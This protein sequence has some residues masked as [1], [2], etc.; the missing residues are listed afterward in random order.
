[1]RPGEQ[2]EGAELSGGFMERN[3]VERTI[4]T[5]IDTRK[6]KRSGQARV[7][8]VKDINRNIPT[9]WRWARGDWWE[10]H[11]LD[12][13]QTQRT[14]RCWRHS[15][16]TVTDNGFGAFTL[17]TKRSAWDTHTLKKRFASVR[18]RIKRLNSCLQ[19]PRLNVI[20]LYPQ[21]KTVGSIESNDW[22]CVQC[23]QSA[24]S[25]SDTP[26]PIV[27]RLSWLG[28][29]NFIYFTGDL[30]GKRSQKRLNNFNFCQP[31]D[32]SGSVVK[33]FLCSK[34]TRGLWSEES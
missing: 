6:S 8:Y 17:R 33:G 12:S 27:S 2:S 1:M 23:D 21:R 9:T 10:Q 3:T 22:F 24:A 31:Q 25:Q 34:W 16:R 7:V 15:R 5:E 30:W 19:I 32:Q 20:F 28:Q 26:D 14:V 11:M 29:H 13:Y 18:A 4:R